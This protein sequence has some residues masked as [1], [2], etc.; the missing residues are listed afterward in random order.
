M[1]RRRNP[2]PS[3]RSAVCL[4]S[5]TPTTRRDLQVYGNAEIIQ[6][7][8][9]KAQQLCSFVSGCMME[10][11]HQSSCRQRALLEGVRT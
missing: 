9:S 10:G 7:T 6:N 1:H 4:Q 2:E 3:H 11:A 8:P 5:C